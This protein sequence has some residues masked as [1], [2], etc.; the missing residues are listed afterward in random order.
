MAVQ[1]KW[2]AEEKKKGDEGF[3]NA[4]ILTFN[5]HAINSFVRELFQNSND[6]RIPGKNKVVIQ[7]SYCTIRKSD[8]PVFDQFKK[9]L[10][11]VEKSHPHQ[12]KFFKKAH[13]AIKGDKIPFLV[14]SDY[15]TKGLEGKDNDSNQSFSACVLSEGISAKEDKSAGGSFGIGKNAIYGISNLR[16]VF[17]SSLNKDEEHIFQGVAKLASYK[18]GNK[19]HE[20][21]IYLGNGDERASV[22]KY[23]DIPEVF[24]RTAPGLSQ[25]VMGVELEADWHIE[26]AKAVLR[27]YWMLLHQGKLEVELFEDKI[28]IQRISSRNVE[29][30]MTELFSQEA[31]QDES[32]TPYGNPY[33]F[34]QAVVKGQQ[35]NFEIPLIGPCTFHYMESEAGEN[36]VAYLRNGMVIFSHIEPRLVGVTTT[37]VFL[38]NNRNGNQVL[39]MMEPPK[40]DSFEAQML[41]NNDEFLT[42]KDGEAILKSIKGSIRFLIRELI[43][44]YK[45]PT[46]TPAFLT[47]L[48][49]D[50]QK[51]FAE[52]NKG[53]RN[54]TPSEA[55]TIHRRAKEDEL[56]VNLRSEQENNYV[57]ATKGNH[58]GMGSGDLPGAVKQPVKKESKTKRKPG[59][60]NG[61]G[62][63]PKL[64]LKSRV[65]H[66]SERNGRNV[67]KAILHSEDHIDSAEL[68]LYQHSD[69]GDEVAFTLHAAT[70]ENGNQ[71]KVRAIHDS[72]GIIKEYKIATD[73]P[74]AKVL[75]LEISDHQKSA[76]IIKG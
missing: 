47:E 18:T 13:E 7:I 70:D 43:D 10:D 6:A 51:S 30:L 4:G 58:Q 76:F 48:F 14:Y 46:E 57:S 15:N 9:V 32:L 49:D 12:V 22:R 40:H 65:F 16:T 39:R 2:G 54:N 42:R 63:T 19:N 17:Y 75:F 29:S 28:S 69:S 36:N 44:K 59:S 55:E 41:D 52:A 25:Y 66:F 35:A 33:L 11:Q 73:I 26:F 72:D 23:K 71:V 5:S 21:R 8:I 64:S 3:N 56:A 74:G 61:S 38:C 37:G 20:G 60:L 1:W 24:R 45:Q 67:Y 34:Y 50:L 68:N 31:E 27:N 62:R 53:N